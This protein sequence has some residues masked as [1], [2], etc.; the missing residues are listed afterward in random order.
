MEGIDRRAD[1]AG[2]RGVA[3]GLA[4]DKFDTARRATCVP[5]ACVQL[6]DSQIV[7]QGQDQPFALGHFVLA[8]PFDG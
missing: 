3:I 8:H 7:F 4:V 5:A 2:A 1:S 6:V